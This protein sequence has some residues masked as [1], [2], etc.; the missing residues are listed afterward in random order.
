MRAVSGISTI[1]GYACGGEELVMATTVRSGAFLFAALLLT[2][3][4][5]LTLFGSDP[6]VGSRSTPHTSPLLKVAFPRNMPPLQMYANRH[7]VKC[8]TLRRV[9]H[10]K[11]HYEQHGEL[12]C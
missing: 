8:I 6:F 10:C 1:K 4:Q 7:L 5:G 2:T 11:L 3:K 9:L 12:L